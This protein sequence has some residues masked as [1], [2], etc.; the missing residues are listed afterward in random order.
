MAEVKIML[1]EELMQF[2]QTQV[3]DGKYFSP[4]EY[5]VD[6]VDKAERR[7]LKKELEEKLLEG[8]N[9]P[10]EDIDEEFWENLRRRFREKYRQEV[11]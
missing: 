2:V 9:S 3:S 1:L 4:S 11:T 10:I 6:L 5:V 8:L 7:A